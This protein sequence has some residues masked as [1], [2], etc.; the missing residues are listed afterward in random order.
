MKKVQISLI[1]TLILLLSIPTINAAEIEWHDYD[2]GMNLAASEGRIAMIYFHSDKCPACIR[3]DST[4]FSDPK[5]IELSSNFVCVDVKG[6][7]KVLAKYYVRAY[8]TIVF[9]GLE[10]EEI[11]RLPGYREAPAFTAYAEAI[12][13]GPRHL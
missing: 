6:D 9:V 13:E 10:G 4:T 1:I 12:L 7:R 3:L 11:F 8:P 2:E 5:I